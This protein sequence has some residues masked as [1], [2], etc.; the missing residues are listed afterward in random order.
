M[1]HFSTTLLCNAS[2]THFPATLFYNNPLN[3]SLSTFSATIPLQHLSATPLLKQ[4]S[5]RHF[6]PTL[7]CNNL[8]NTFL[9]TL[10]ATLLYRTFLQ[11]VSVNNTSLQP[12]PATLLTTLF[13]TFLCNTPLQHFPQHFYT[14]ILCNYTITTKPQPQNHHYN[15]TQHSHATAQHQYNA[16]TKAP[17]PPAHYQILQH[18]T[19]HTLP[20]TYSSTAVGKHSSTLRPPLLNSNPSLRIRESNNLPHPPSWNISLSGPTD[21]STFFQVA[22][23]SPFIFAAATISLTVLAP[24]ASA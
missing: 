24:W 11:H 14:A 2:L 21:L 1:P 5:L 10:S 15:T 13:P 16:T 18:H 4:P 8:G 7:L 17:S 22:F 6:S 20:C 23:S 19:Y 9:S 3:T 12:F